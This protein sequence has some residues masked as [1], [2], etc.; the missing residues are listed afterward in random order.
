MMGKKEIKV[1][2]ITP[3]YISGLGRGK[4]TDIQL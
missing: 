3:A 4:T 2:V 1:E